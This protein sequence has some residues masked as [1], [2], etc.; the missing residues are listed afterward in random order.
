M[1]WSDKYK[2]S[3][4]CENPKGFSQR[5]YCQ[6]R[7]KKL[8]EFKD[9]I[10]THIALT[11]MEQNKQITTP[12]VEKHEETSAVGSLMEKVLKRGDSYVV[13]DSQGKKVLGKHKTR[14]SALRQIAAIEASKARRMDEGKLRDIGKGLMQGGALGALTVGLAIGTNSSNESGAKEPVPD[15]GQVGQLE[16]KPAERPSFEVSRKD[17]TKKITQPKEDPY[18]GRFDEIVSMTRNFE[19]GN[20]K[21]GMSITHPDPI[22][23]NKI[24][25]NA[26]QTKAG[27]SQSQKDY[28]TSKGHD[29]DALFTIGGSIPKEDAHHLTKLRME[30]DTQHLTNAYTNFHDH[31]H[32]VKAILHDLSYNLGRTGLSKFKNFNEAINNRDYKLAADHLKDSLYYRQTGR[33]GKTHVQTLRSL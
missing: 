32:Q 17:V 25:T 31:P 6:G 3:I 26:G 16:D 11:I 10:K 4:D 18:G 20:F 27:L 30:A 12:D 13:T 1:T 9:A 15:T 5:A 28:L 23:G 22:H 19:G 24:P 14:S 21:D 8:R 2:R 29:I 33:R 7:K